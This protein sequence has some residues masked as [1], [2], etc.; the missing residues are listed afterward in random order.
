MDK[1]CLKEDRTLLISRIIDKN[2]K[3][4]KKRK[5]PLIEVQGKTIKGLTIYI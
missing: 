4:F 1:G 2:V 3:I 5:Y